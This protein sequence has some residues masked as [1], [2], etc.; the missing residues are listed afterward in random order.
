MHHAAKRGRVAH[1]VADG[2]SITG[3][4][5]VAD[6][7][8]DP[9]AIADLPPFVCSA[10][11]VVEHSRVGVRSGHAALPIVRPW[12]HLDGALDR[13]RSRQH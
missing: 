2:V 12:G 6:E 1:S 5:F 7:L 9:I 11:R 10:Q 3:A 8:T 13:A 4:N